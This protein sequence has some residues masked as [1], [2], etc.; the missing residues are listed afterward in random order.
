MLWFPENRGRP[1]NPFKAPVASQIFQAVPLQTCKSFDKYHVRV[2]FLF[3]FSL[4]SVYS[5]RWE[6]I[7]GRESTISGIWRRKQQ[8]GGNRWKQGAFLLTLSSR[9][10]TQMILRVSDSQ[11]V[12]THFEF[13]ASPKIQCTLS[14]ILQPNKRYSNFWQLNLLN[15]FDKMWQFLEMCSYRVIFLT[16]P[17]PL[18][19]L[20]AKT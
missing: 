12:L 1:S 14:G 9:A 13:W 18:K 6:C 8:Q 7:I 20:S 17:P 2:S 4:Q 19:L 16:T 5:G 11:K 15:F 3:G 10:G